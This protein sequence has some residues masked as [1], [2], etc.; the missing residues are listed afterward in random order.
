MY[1]T[2]IQHLNNIESKP[3]LEWELFSLEEEV[4]RLLDRF[5][6]CSCSVQMNYNSIVVFFIKSF[7]HKLS[8]SW[9]V[10]MLHVNMCM[11]DARGWN[12]AYKI[13]PLL[14]LD[15]FAYLPCCYVLSALW[16]Q[17]TRRLGRLLNQPL[18]CTDLTT[19]LYKALLWEL[20]ISALPLICLIYDK[21][22]CLGLI[23]CLYKMGEAIW[24][25][26]PEY[27]RI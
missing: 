17:D 20:G 25:C 23:F 19:L 4:A 27:S 11:R 10:L 12:R 26:F 22:V 5:G 8:D 13:S 7:G 21:S 9:L 15:L 24:T 6:W 1:V 3:C 14:W 18:M 16:G 2:V